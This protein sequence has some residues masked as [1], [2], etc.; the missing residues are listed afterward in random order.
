M[1]WYTPNLLGSILPSLLSRGKTLPISPDDTM[2]P[3]IL[4]CI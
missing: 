4:L 3:Y 1:T 2:L